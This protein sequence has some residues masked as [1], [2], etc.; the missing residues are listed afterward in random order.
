M[1]TST[2]VRSGPSAGVLFVL[3]LVFPKGERASGPIT[4]YQNVLLPGSSSKE[5]KGCVVLFVAF[6]QLLW[7]SNPDGRN[8]AQNSEDESLE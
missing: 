8:A 3:G 4:L 7:L 1:S 2:T 6:G 5:L